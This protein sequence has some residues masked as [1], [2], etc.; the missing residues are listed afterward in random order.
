MVIG[1]QVRPG[2]RAR[3]SPLFMQPSQA[4]ERFRP[5]AVSPGRAGRLQASEPTRRDLWGSWLSRTSVRWVLGARRPHW[6]Y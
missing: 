4:Q 3:H 2:F 1:L 6:T 5:R